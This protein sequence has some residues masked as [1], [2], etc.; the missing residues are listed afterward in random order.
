MTRRLV[1]RLDN[2]GDVVLAGP[3]VRAVAAS[4]SP[5]TFLAGPTGAPAARLLPGVGDVIEFD[6]P[7]VSFDPPPVDRAAIATLVDTVAAARIDEAIIVTSFHQSPLPLALLLRQA[8]VASIAATCVDYPGALLDVR[9]SYV[10]EVHEVEQA[11]MVCAALGHV[12]P[13]DDDGRLRIDVPPREPGDPPTPYVVVHPGASVEARALPARPANEALAA[14]VGE[15][16]HVAVTGS[17]G[18]AALAARVIGRHTSDDRVRDLTG[19]TD[20]VEFAHLVAGA[21][22]VVCGNTAAAHVAA[23]MGTPVVEAFAPVVPAH[24]WRPWRV[25]HVLLGNLDIGCAG[26]RSRECPVPNQ[27]CLQPFTATAV[28]EAVAGLARAAESDSQPLER[29]ASS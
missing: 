4:G 16:F 13:S 9:H 18:E 25:P 12:L 11:L 20:L 24:R 19:R 7:W 5:V 17:A 8:G 26:C 21:A 10:D 2:V 3:A 27:P 29:L 1:A 23:A 22:A 15:G 14:L 6:A 28:V